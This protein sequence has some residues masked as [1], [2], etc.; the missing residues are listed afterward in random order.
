MRL[1][2]EDQKQWPPQRL[3]IKFTSKS[4]KTAGFRPNQYLSNWASHMRGLGPSFMRFGH[5][6]ALREMGPEMPESGSKTS[7]V[8]V[9]GARNSDRKNPLENF[10]PRFFGIKTA[11][12]S[13]IIFQRAQLST[14]NTTHLCWSNW[15]I[16]WRKNASGRSPMG[17]CSCTSVPRLS[18]H[19]QPKIN[20]PTWASSVLIIHPI[21]WILL[22]RTTTFSLDWK[23]QL[24]VRHFS[25]TRRSLLSRRP[26][27]IY[28]ILNFFWVACKS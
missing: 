2:L 10:S 19:L 4:W 7:T 6:E 9:V 15:R 24:K 14:R 20:W 3:L 11:S 16:F 22:R 28:H 12:S 8:P 27:W 21:L 5:A 13:L 23:K 1:I 25:P 26:G 18:G 17:S